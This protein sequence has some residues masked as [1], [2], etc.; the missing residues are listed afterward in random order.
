MSRCFGNTT[1]S[2]SKKSGWVHALKTVSA[3]LM[4]IRQKKAVLGLCRKDW[5]LLLQCRGMSGTLPPASNCREHCEQSR[6]YAL[7]FFPSRTQLSYNRQLHSLSFIAFFSQN[8]PHEGQLYFQFV[9]S[10]NG[11]H[12]YLEE[13][14]MHRRVFGVSLAFRFLSALDSFTQGKVDYESY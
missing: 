2:N 14:Q 1:L 9:T 12:Q 6:E 3:Q 8:V 7:A 4:S 5:H 13:F 10:Y 11:E